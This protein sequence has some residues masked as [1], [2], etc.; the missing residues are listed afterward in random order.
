[1]PI[2]SLSR[3]RRGVLKNGV[4]LSLMLFYFSCGKE[5]FPPDLGILYLLDL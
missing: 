1:M 5:V 3:Y 2:M 4:L